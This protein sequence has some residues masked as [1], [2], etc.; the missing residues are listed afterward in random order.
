MPQLPPLPTTPTTAA[1]ATAEP[2]VAESTASLDTQ[3]YGRVQ[4]VVRDAHN[5]FRYRGYCGSIHCSQKVGI[6]QEGVTVDIPKD[7]VAVPP[8]ERPLS[9]EAAL[10]AS[11]DPCIFMH[12]GSRQGRIFAALL[13][14]LERRAASWAGIKMDAAGVDPL[15]EASSAIGF[16][17]PFFNL[18]WEVA[19]SLSIYKSSLLRW[20][21]HA[22]RLR[23]DG[24]R[25]AASVAAAAATLVSPPAPALPAEVLPPDAASL[26]Q[27]A[28]AGEPAQL[29]TVPV[30]ESQG[31]THSQT[32]T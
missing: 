14:R 22:T 7:E 15:L 1:A 29:E 2:S 13:E 31:D 21:E 5:L 11:L 26:E 10:Q 25:T 16:T 27:P 32:Q 8:W 9:D 12:D 4:M 23:L 24:A 17:L 20:S 30:D 6:Y 3:Q 28:T 18:G 19:V